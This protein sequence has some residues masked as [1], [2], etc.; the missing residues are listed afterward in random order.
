VFWCWQHL[1]L[2]LEEEGLDLVTQ[3]P[4]YPKIG[5]CNADKSVFYVGSPEGLCPFCARPPDYTLP[6]TGAG[7]AALPA[8]FMPAPEAAEPAEQ[9][10]I[11]SQCPNCQ[12]MV[13]VVITDSDVQ[14]V[15]AAPAVI[16]EPSAE[17]AVPPP[18]AEGSSPTVD[19][20]GG[21]PEPV[22]T[23]ATRFPGAARQAHPLPETLDG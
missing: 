16:E 1:Q 8:A 22:I 2:E 18:P 21:T 14:I 5:G 10:D 3:S 6:F 15:P 23:S 13:R 11:P 20:S 4:D 12:A 9:I 19:S 7:L 17:A